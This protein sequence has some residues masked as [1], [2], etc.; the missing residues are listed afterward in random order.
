MGKIV[1]FVSLLCIQGAAIFGQS[2]VS[3]DLATEHQTMAGFGA[4]GGVKAYWQEPP[5]YTDQFL[6][7]FIEDLGTSIV[8]T[9][10]FWDLEPTNDNPFPYAPDQER[11]RISRCTMTAGLPP[12]FSRYTNK[13]LTP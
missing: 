2:K 5:F 7:Y 8:R 9:N 1:L 6:D 12:D 10:I 11:S 13:S 3:I 4:F